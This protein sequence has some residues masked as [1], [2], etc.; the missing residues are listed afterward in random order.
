MFAE[1]LKFE[2]AERQ[3]RAVKFD[4]ITELMQQYKKPLLQSAWDLQS[5]LTNQVKLG[6]CYSFQQRTEREKQYGKY[7]TMY[8]VA[9]FL[10][11][12]E[13]IRREI[14]FIAAL[15]VGAEAQGRETESSDLSRLFE[16]IK[17][18]F[19]GETPWQGHSKTPVTS[20]NEKW[21]SHG[22]ILQLYAGELRAIGEVM[23]VTTGTSTDTSE[24]SG[25]NGSLYPIGYAEFVRRMKKKA[26]GGECRSRAR[27]AASIDDA[28]RKKASVSVK[29]WTTA[30]MEWDDSKEKQF[31]ET[32][33]PLEDYVDQLGR[34]KGPEKEHI[35]AGALWKGQAPTKRMLMLQ[36]LM[37]KLIDMLDFETKDEPRYIKRNERLIPLVRYLNQDQRDWLCKQPYFSKK[38]CQLQFPGFLEEGDRTSYIKVDIW[39]DDAMPQLPK[40]YYP[41]VPLNHTHRMLSRRMNAGDSGTVEGIPV[42]TPLRQRTRARVAPMQEENSAMPARGPG[43]YNNRPL[44]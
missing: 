5:R 24:D 36:V 38:D 28:T 1:E 27:S 19:T 13:I 8:V 9:E 26:P 35:E 12:L 43:M 33:K 39:A 23:L 29:E 40:D 32:L 17:F 22:H 34:L 11:W 20:S 10:A 25:S 42:P 2:I 15:K 4:D 37:C 16:D 44:A 41:T 31:Q 7:N 3:R 30:Q 18:Q 14:V 21:D 6:F